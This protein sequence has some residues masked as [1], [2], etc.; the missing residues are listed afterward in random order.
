M[1]EVARHGA[2]LLPVDSEHNAIWQC[3]DRNRADTID[4]IILT[5]AAVRFASAPSKT[6]G[7]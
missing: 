1:D 3:F 6:C 4:R 7:G 5:A 2:T